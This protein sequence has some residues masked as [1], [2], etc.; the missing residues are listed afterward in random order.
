MVQFHF[1]YSASKYS[2]T[3]PY[4]VSPERPISILAVTYFSSG[5]TFLDVFRPLSSHPVLAR[6]QPGH[7][8]CL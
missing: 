8:S 3:S 6:W 2:A 4:L 7:H 1:N 5:N